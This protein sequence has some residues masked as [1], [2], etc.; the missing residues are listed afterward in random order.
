MFVHFFL[1]S[2]FDEEPT[3]KGNK[4]MAFVTIPVAKVV[5]QLEPTPLQSD[6]ANM[7]IDIPTPSAHMNMKRQVAA[8]QCDPVESNDTK[9]HVDARE[10][11]H[12]E[13]GIIQ[14]AFD[15]VTPLPYIES[16]CVSVEHNM[17]PI[18]GFQESF[19]CTDITRFATIASHVGSKNIKNLALCDPGT[20]MVENQWIK[21]SQADNN[22]SLFFAPG[23]ITN[24]SLYVDD[25]PSRQISFL[26][27]AC[28]W[29]RLVAVIGAL[30]QRPELYFNTYKGV[31]V[32][33]KSAS[34]GVSYPKSPMTKQ[35]GTSKSKNKS[36]RPGYG[37][38][39]HDADIPMYDGTDSFN[40]SRL[41]QA[42]R[43]PNMDLPEG[44]G[45]IVIFAVSTYKPYGTQP[46]KYRLTS[47]DIVVSLNIHAV[48]VITWTD[49]DFS[50]KRC[51]EVVVRDEAL[52]VTYPSSETSDHEL[53]GSSGEDE[54]GATDNRFGDDDVAPEDEVV[55]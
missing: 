49:P 41:D 35:R 31:T 50:L 3:S 30:V 46:V 54:A 19:P 52:G 40:L 24:C 20:L 7:E 1:P 2:D 48:V 55:L 38:L 34:G 5:D 47:S 29:Y 42:T 11:D 33:T 10:Y 27:F 8:A 9:S 21:H 13:I 37:S 36:F 28:T 25:A 4:G 43:L 16:R 45:I 51:S 6:T 26:P 12:R 15:E 14:R 23:I 44:V 39:N 17:T 53:G 18:A 22:Y 32:S